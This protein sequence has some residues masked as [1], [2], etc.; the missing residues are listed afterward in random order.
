MVSIDKIKVWKTSKIM[1]YIFAVIGLFF[2]ILFSI[3]VILGA[4]FL[5][6]LFEQPLIAGT[7]T[8]VIILFSII[9]IPLIFA[10][11]GMI[12]ASILALIYNGI[13]YVFGGIEFELGK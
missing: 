3:F 11:V 8:A 5:N 12:I 7:S 4:G 10:L 1:I 2:A 13:A 9:L 6:T